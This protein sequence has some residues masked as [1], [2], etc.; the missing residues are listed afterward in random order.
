MLS[1]S[2]KQRLFFAA[3]WQKRGGY[4]MAKI[5]TVITSCVS[6]ACAIA[7]FSSSPAQARDMTVPSPS[8]CAALYFAFAGPNNDDPNYLAMQSLA[9]SRG[10]YQGLSQADATAQDKGL[11]IFIQKDPTYQ[12]SEG[13]TQKYSDEFYACSV[14]YNIRPPARA[15]GGFF[16]AEGFEAMWAQDAGNHQH[17]LAAEEEQAS[18]QAKANDQ[19]SARNKAYGQANSVLNRCMSMPSSVDMANPNYANY[20]QLKWQCEDIRKEAIRIAQANGDNATA[21][22]YIKLR[23]PWQ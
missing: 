15:I 6:I 20:T 8:V 19:N 14:F 1:G 4:V 13:L 21:M 5:K 12:D 16:E 9:R 7:T 3:M 22:D 23:F 17:K 10:S 18:A 11:A 2:S